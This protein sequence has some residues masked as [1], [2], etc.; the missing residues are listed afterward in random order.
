MVKKYFV[1]ENCFSEVDIVSCYWA[2][3]I[4]ADGSVSGKGG[5]SMSLSRKDHSHLESF[6]KFVELSCPV[7]IFENKDGYLYSSVS[8]SSKEVCFDLE[9][10]YNIIPNKTFLCAFPPITNR[11][12]IDA[13]IVGYI[14]GDGCLYSNKKTNSIDLSIVGTKVFLEWII[15]RFEEI[16][17]EKIGHLRKTKSVYTFYC[18]KRKAFLLLEHLNKIEVP[19]LNRKWD[20]VKTIRQD[21]GTYLEWTPEELDILKQNHSKMSCRKIMETFLPYRTYEGIEKRIH[22]L[23]LKK[24]FEVKWEKEEDLLLRTYYGKMSVRQI[25]ETLFPYRTFSSVK[26]RTTKIREE[27]ANK[28]S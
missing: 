3:F 25:Q 4:T 24:H 11:D 15:K 17:N 18:N 12:F 19:K 7:R 20:K 10:K 23:G 26:N 22:L 14:D 1:N 9:Q 13:F 16:L 27:N 28:K 8:F 5:F 21:Y 2:G 6:A